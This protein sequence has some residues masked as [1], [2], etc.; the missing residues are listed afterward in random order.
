V[1]AAGSA[2]GCAVHT[3]DCF[4][5][6]FFKGLP[7]FLCLL[8]GPLWDVQYLLKQE[9]QEQVSCKRQRRMEELEQLLH[10]GKSREQVR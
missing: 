6:A 5:Q 4:L 9:L 8:Q 10:P 1:L 3:I 2:L 7:M